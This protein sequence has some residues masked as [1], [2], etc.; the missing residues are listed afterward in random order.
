MVL[1]ASQK[2]SQKYPVNAGPSM[3]GPAFFLL[4]INELPDNALCSII[5]YVDD[6]TLYSQRD[7]A[8]DLQQQLQLVFKLEFDQQDT[9]DWGKEQLVDFNA[10]KT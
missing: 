2:S 7:Q 1:D 3:L 4:Y 8:S 6:T 9:A 10:G 5:I